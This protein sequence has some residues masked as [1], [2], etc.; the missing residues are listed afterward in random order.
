MHSRDSSIGGNEILLFTANDLFFWGEVTQTHE[1][2]LD[3]ISTPQLLKVELE[4]FVLLDTARVSHESKNHLLSCG[5][6][7]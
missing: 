7:D 2:H 6:R 5:E 3:T 4:R 1:Q